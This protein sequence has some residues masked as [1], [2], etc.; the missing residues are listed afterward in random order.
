MRRIGGRLQSAPCGGGGGTV[1][2]P[3]FSDSVSNRA[4][5]SGAGTAAAGQFDWGGRLDRDTNVGRSDGNIRGKPGCMLESPSRDLCMYPLHA[6]VV[7]AVSGATRLQTE[8]SE[9]A[10]RCGQSAGKSFFDEVTPQRLYAGHPSVR[11]MR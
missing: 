4:P 9:N 2:I 5:L 10:L 6:G 11:V 7:S 1:E 8:G 3:P